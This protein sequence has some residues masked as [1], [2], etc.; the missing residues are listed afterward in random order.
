MD[1]IG[2]IYIPIAVIFTVYQDIA[3]SVLAK[4]VDEFLSSPG[5]NGIF[6]R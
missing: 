6:Y 4:F 3:I 5:H 1:Y 2:H